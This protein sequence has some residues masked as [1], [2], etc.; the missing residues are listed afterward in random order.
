MAAGAWGWVR[1]EPSPGAEYGGGGNLAVGGNPAT[2]PVVVPGAEYGGGGSLVAGPL[3]EG[4]R[5]ELGG[6]RGL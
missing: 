4:R 2:S 5:E 3:V 1:G 6:A